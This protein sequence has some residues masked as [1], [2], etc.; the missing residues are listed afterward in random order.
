MVLENGRW[1]PR[2]FAFVWEWEK[3]A[4]LPANITRSSHVNVI[5]TNPKNRRISYNLSARIVDPNKYFQ[6]AGRIKKNSESI[7]ADISA[8]LRFWCYEFNEANSKDLAMFY[9]PDDQVQRL[10]FNELVENWMNSKLMDSGL[11]IRGTGFS[12]E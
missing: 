1:Q 2:E 8:S 4:N 5:T 11:A 12:I 3:F 7:E 6:V 9:N 10:R